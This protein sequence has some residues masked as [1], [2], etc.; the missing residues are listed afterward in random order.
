MSGGSA[1]NLYWVAA[2]LLGG[3]G[4]LLLL[5]PVGATDPLRRRNRR[6]AGVLFLFAGAVFAA[7]AAGL[8]QRLLG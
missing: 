3:A 4:I 7:V 2:V 1:F 6:T 5:L 8:V